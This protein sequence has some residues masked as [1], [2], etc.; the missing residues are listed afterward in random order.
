MYI[1]VK[2]IIYKVVYKIDI[3]THMEKQRCKQCEWK[4]PTWHQ[5][6][7]SA[8]FKGI[9][10]ADMTA[11]L[12]KLSARGCKKKKKPK[13]VQGYLSFLHLL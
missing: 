10:A 13:Q 9:E 2:S 4:P 11:L 8:V 12:H 7:N 5:T 6:M 1:A 3:H